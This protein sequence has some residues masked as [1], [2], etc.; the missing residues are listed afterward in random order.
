MVGAHGGSVQAL[1][2]RDGRG[3]LIR[4]TLPLLQPHPADDPDD[5]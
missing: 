1:P 3:T 5:S 4:I 2:G